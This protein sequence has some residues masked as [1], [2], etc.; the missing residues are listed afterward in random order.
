MI[1]RFTLLTFVLLLLLL[2]SVTL[3]QE[4]TWDTCPVIVQTA[5]AAADAACNETGSNQ[6]CY[7]NIS[8]E[9]EPQTGISGLVFDAPGDQ[10][11]V[12]SVRTLRLSSMNLD[13]DEWGVS[14]LRIRANLPEALGENA[15][16][17]LFGNVQLDAAESAPENFGPMQAFYFQSGLGDAPCAEAP[18]SGILI[19]TPEGVAEVNLLVNE[20]DIRLGS[21][22]YLQAQ[23][24]GE[25]TINVVEGGAT[26]IA[27]N[28]AVYAPAG[29]RV[30]VL[31][32]AN[33]V[34]SGAPIG[35]EPYTN[36]DLVALPMSNLARDVGV[37]TALTAEEIE[38]LIAGILPIPGQWFG[39]FSRTD[40]PPSQVIISPP[41]TIVLNV[42]EDGAGLSFGSGVSYR[43]IEP[44]QYVVDMDNREPGNLIVISPSYIQ[45]DWSIRKG[46]LVCHMYGSLSLVADAQIENSPISS[47]G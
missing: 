28:V 17:L 2:V 26:I 27:A 7:G 14:L 45:Y 37:E 29:T 16:L 4:D 1:V 25:M 21:T 19:Q 35:P 41:T 43:R 42:D 18:D 33:G 12:D 36:T 30:R 11:D 38:T 9:A 6:A 31:L 8:L 5:L 23:P 3:A 32:D 20:V 44:R 15:E 22:A 47:G 46:E 34:A 24:N 10:V 13:T 40:C 39:G